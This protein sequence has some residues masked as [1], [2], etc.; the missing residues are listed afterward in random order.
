MKREE[1][2]SFEAML[3]AEQ[4]ERIGLSQERNLQLC[5]TRLCSDFT[6]AERARDAAED[7]LRLHGYR[8]SCDI[9]ACNCGDGWS[10]GGHAAERLREIGDLVWENGVTPLNS[11]RRLFSERDALRTQLKASESRVAELVR[12][13]EA[14]STAL[15]EAVIYISKEI[16]HAERQLDL[17]TL[18]SLGTLRSA[19]DRAV[20][21]MQ[22]VVAAIALRGDCAA[23]ATDAPGDTQ[24]GKR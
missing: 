18:L 2:V 4:R 15:R 6:D 13:R 22:K 3:T 11:V 24:E 17:D 12:E 7:A 23:L 16:S 19:A 5:I 9:P 21:M 14:I 8:N 10:H 1:W 20:S